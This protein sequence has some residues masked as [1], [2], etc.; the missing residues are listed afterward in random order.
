[1]PHLPPKGRIEWNLNTLVTIS[2]ILVLFIGNAFA[3]GVI[4]NTMQNN[5]A[6]NA[7]AISD[8]KDAVDSE[9]QARKERG[10][11]TDAKF[12]AIEDK[13]PQFE[14]IN[15]QILRLTEIQGQTMQ[16]IVEA[17]K[18]MDRMTESTAGKLDTIIARQSDQSA[19]IKVIQSQLADQQRLQRT[20]FPVHYLRK[21]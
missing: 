11:L 21:Q 8:A 2:G 3:M 20:R 12:K 4:Y 1:M 19:D 15:Q 13:L 14:L 6:S 17:N 7:A 9:R 18:R 5:D 10:A 16:S